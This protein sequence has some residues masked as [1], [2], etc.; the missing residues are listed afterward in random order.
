MRWSLNKRVS[1]GFAVVLVILVIGE[2]ISYQSTEHLLNVSRQLTQTQQVLG[3]LDNIL[4]TMDD[5]ETGQRGYLLTGKESY[6]DPYE[7]AVARLPEVVGSLDKLTAS[8]PVQQRYIASLE[9][10]I[11]LKQGELATTIKLRKANKT[12]VA[13]QLV[14]SGRGKH[15]MDDIRGLIENMRTHENKLMAARKSN[16]EASTRRTRLLIGSGVF[17]A[18]VFLL[19][20]VLALNSEALRRLRVEQDLH[21]SESRIRLLV[22]SVRDYAILMLD[23]QGK[24]LSWSP[25]AERIKGYKAEEII[26][27]NWS[28]FFLSE[29]IQA[30]KP[31]IELEMA[32][33]NGRAEH[34]GWRVRKD[35][36]RFWANVVIAAVRNDRGQLRGFSKVTRDITEQKQ[37]QEEIQKLNRDLARRA[38]ELEAANKELEAF[39]YSVSHDLRAPLRHVDGF[40]QLLVEEYGPQLPEEVRRYLARIQGGARQMGLLVD[41]L[42]NLARIGRKEI[43]LQVTGLGPLVEQVVSDL[44]TETGDRAIDWKIESLPFVECDPGLVKQVFANLLSNAVKYTRPRER[45]VIEVGSVRNNGQPAIFV[46]DNGVGFNMKYADKLFGVF[47]RL[48]RAEDFEGTGVGL[49]TVQRII[50]KHGG[51]VWAEAELDKGATFYFTLG[52]P[53]LST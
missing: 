13:A 7:G 5:A 46:R 40:S 30:G 10:I 34:E 21:Q 41:D 49:A 15:A 11:K 26:G 22:D 24:V 18:F 14:L 3:T 52:G 16:W 23:P 6:L 8:D 27:Q 25:G 12:A 43:R 50:H 28:C 32:L 42:L 39:T 47:Q 51:R 1:S 19:L 2:F 33:A 4:L 9:G 31:Q 35:G 20:A 45:S 37:A 44:K 29:E 48:H 17:V 53:E 36:S 38:S